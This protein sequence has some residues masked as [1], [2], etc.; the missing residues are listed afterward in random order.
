[1]THGRHAALPTG[2]PAPI[3]SAASPGVAE[4][5]VCLAALGALVELVLVDLQLALRDER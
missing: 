1:M 5:Q 4:A 2:S 3:G